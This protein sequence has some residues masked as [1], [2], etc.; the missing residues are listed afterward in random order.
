[1]TAFSYSFM[2][3]FVDDEDRHR[4]EREGP[5]HLKGDDGQIFYILASGGR[6]GWMM[7]VVSEEDAKA[8]GL[9]GL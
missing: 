9:I 7:P 8:M 6:P 3:T 4:L 1:M 5:R 2:E